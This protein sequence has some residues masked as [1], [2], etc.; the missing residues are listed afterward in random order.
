MNAAAQRTQPRDPQL[1]S[2]V[3]KG[4]QPAG[5]QSASQRVSQSASQPTNS[6]LPTQSSANSGYLYFLCAC[7]CACVYA[8]V[9]VCVVQIVCFPQ[10]TRAEL[11][12]TLGC[13]VVGGGAMVASAARL[14]IAAPLQANL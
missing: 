13:L 4:K 5:N 6:N 10:P 1:T 7:L 9:C 2:N 11:L 8:C 14:N 12:D 3:S